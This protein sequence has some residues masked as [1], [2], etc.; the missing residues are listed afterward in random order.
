MIM[1]WFTVSG[2]LILLVSSVYAYLC[3]YSVLV[4][5]PICR[6]RSNHPFCF[7]LPSFTVVKVSENEKKKNRV[8]RV[9]KDTFVLRFWRISIHF[10]ATMRDKSVETLS[11]QRVFW[12]MLFK[13]YRLAQKKTI[14]LPP[15]NVGFPIVQ[16][17]LK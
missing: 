17:M 16:A 3:T 8:Q 10:V 14:P 5:I 11:F 7:S 9:R 12:C 1:H 6:L 13:Y 4:A 15:T 2:R